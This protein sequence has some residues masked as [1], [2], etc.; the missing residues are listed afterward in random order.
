MKTWLAGLMLLA[1]SIF[2]C[3][4]GQ[5]AVQASASH[6]GDHVVLTVHFFVP[7]TRGLAW[8][9]LVDFEN[10]AKFLPYLKESKVLSRQENSLRIQQKGVVPVLFFEKN[11]VSVRDIELFPVSEIHSTTVG[12][13][14][15]L[16][17]G[18]TKLAQADKQTEIS[19]H[20][21]WWPTS[22]M[23]E[24]F[25]LDSARDLL[26]RQFTAMREEM[27][28][29]QPKETPN[30]GMAKATLSQSGRNLAAHRG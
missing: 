13:D 22:R 12:G 29:R 18:V 9:V 10:M 20:A 5:S 1:A 11:Y 19:Y 24:G 28:R 2:S 15:G 4:A 8:D 6:E 26:A 7:V 16:T 17:R 23:V 27:L 30:P 14:T 25:G 3:A 21:D